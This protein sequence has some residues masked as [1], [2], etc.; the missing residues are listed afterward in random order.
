V[1]V[2]V[3]A[4]TCGRSDD[5]PCQREQ[6]EHDQP[7]HEQQRREASTGEGDHGVGDEQRHPRQAAHDLGH[8]NRRLGVLMLGHDPLGEPAVEHDTGRRDRS[9]QEGRGVKSRPPAP[10]MP[11][12]D[13]IGAHLRRGVGHAADGE[14]QDS[15]RPQDPKPRPVGRKR[16]AEDRSRAIPGGTTSHGTA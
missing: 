7:G 3:A 6:R 2:G 11:A 14:H 13:G 1:G 15:H 8:R 4:T 10:R 16:A 5:R 9:A 12:G